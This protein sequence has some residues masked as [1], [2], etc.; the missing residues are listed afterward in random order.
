MNKSLFQCQ[1]IFKAEKIIAQCDVENKQLNEENE[2]V[3]KKKMKK[4]K[5]ENKKMKK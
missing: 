1:E 2:K 3:E 4:Q 5:V